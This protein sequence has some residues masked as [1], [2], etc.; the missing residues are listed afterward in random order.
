MKEPG[1]Q[2]EQWHRTV[3][4]YPI[5]SRHAAGGLEQSKAQNLTAVLESWYTM[6]L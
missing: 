1:V 2:Q 4:V 6:G 5:S 3:T